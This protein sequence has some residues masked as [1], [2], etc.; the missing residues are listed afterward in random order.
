MSDLGLS[1]L[2]SG[3]DT[4][5]IVDKLMAVDRQAVTALQNKQLTVTQHQTD[6]KAVSTKLSALQ[7]AASAL[8]DSASWIPTQS[9]TSS[10]DTKV[11]ASVISGAG[12]GGHTVQVDRLASSAQHGYTW[13][14]SATA[15]TISIYYGSDPNATGANQATISVGANAT[16][17]DVA[18]AINSSQTAPVFAAVVKDTDGSDRLVLSARKSGESSDFTVDTSGLQGGQMSEDTD[19]AKTGATLD[20]AFHIDGETTARTSESNSVDNAIPGE[21]LTL[22]AVTS[23]PVSITTNAAT[24][25]KSAITSKVQAFV[26]AY[27]AVVDL[28]RTDIGTKNVVNPQTTQDFQTGTLFGDLG[29][30][31]MLSGLKNTLTQTLSNVGG[32]TSL[33][34]IGI[35]LPKATGGAPTDDAMAGKL[36]FDSSKLSTA[37]DNNFT[38]VQQLF[39]GVGVN[40]GFG[41]QV[42][43]FVNSQNGLNGILTGRMNSD[44][45]SLTHLTSQI[46][47]TNSHLSDEENRLKAQFAN[48]EVAMENAQS[49]QSWLTGQIASLPAAG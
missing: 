18:S 15:G 26:D 42:S 20:A 28:T 29:L 39:D 19:Y 1:G 27:N 2:A 13:T 9:V 49:E 12:I 36:T 41:V 47:D 33:S 3:V 43:D 48:M 30:G 17:A 22:K 32:L 5:G 11:S 38:Q 6:L 23:S 37:L 14:P 25:D 21:R 45:T 4:S 44:A 8:D 16:A 24:V 40:K 10:D 34:D 46:N 7:S 31:N 35:T